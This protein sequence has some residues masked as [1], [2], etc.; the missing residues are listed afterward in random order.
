VVEP[1][2]CRGYAVRL[3]KTVSVHDNQLEIAY[4][5]ENVGTRLIDTHEYAHNFIGIDK[6]NLGPEYH[7]R[8]PYSIQLENL[9]GAFRKMAPPLLRLLPG[10]LLDKL[11]ARI[12]LPGMK[13]V[14]VKGNEIGFRATPQKPLY[15]RPLGFS[16]TDHP[17][18]EIIHQPSGV[19]LREYD[20]FAPSRVV[21][22]GTT[23]VLSAEI[24]VD[25]RLQP[26]E[27]KTWLR[28]YE[29]FA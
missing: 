9:S 10:P 16:Q 26:G 20:D 5:L 21:V 2:D 28:R 13:V 7:L 19:G 14:E 1:I 18:W 8:L 24:Y 17:Q 11:I 3:T 23:H 29:F 6:Q 25:I 15:C 4:R 12:A 27:T 22:W